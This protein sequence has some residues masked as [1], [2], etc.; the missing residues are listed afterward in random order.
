LLPPRPQKSA[1]AR[2]IHGQSLSFS[3]ESRHDLLRI[4]SKLN[5]FKRH[6]PLDRLLLLGHVNDA[7]AAF[8]NLLEQLVG[9]D[10]RPGAFFNRQ[11]QADCAPWACGWRGD[12]FVLQKCVR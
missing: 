10:F 11:T 6:T 5:D 4:H 3:L 9:A 8:A 12:G 2:P 1:D 7:A